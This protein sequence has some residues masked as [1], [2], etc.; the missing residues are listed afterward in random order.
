MKRFYYLGY[1]LILAVCLALEL[2][3]LV[4]LRS[5]ITKA[6]GL[7]LLIQLFTKIPFI[8]HELASVRDVELLAKEQERNTGTS[9]KDFLML[10]IPLAIY[11]IV[12]GF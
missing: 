5:F 2:L 8:S 10:L 12:S 4:F 11:Y 1:V 7:L 3:H 6:I 9:W